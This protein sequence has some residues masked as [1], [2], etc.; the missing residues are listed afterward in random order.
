MTIPIAFSALKMSFDAV[1]TASK[2]HNQVEIDLRSSEF[3]KQI[4]ELYSSV[5]GLYEKNAGLVT[6]KADLEKKLLSYEQWEK[7]AARYKLEEI[8]TQVFVYAYK[9]SNENQDPMHYLCAK[10]MN[11]KKKSILNLDHESSDG[12]KSYHC[13]SCDKYL[14]THSKRHV[15]LNPYPSRGQGSQ[16][17]MS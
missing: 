15:P 7:E 6:E 5:F 3:L 16:G 1:V 9:K 4:D 2:L 13:P 14:S 10:C 11:D 12:S 17:W 8:D